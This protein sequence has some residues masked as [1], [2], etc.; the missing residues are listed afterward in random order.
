MAVC[1]Q[2]G[3][4]KTSLILA[5][6]Q[7]M[8]IQEGSITIDGMN[9]QELEPES[10]RTC[11]SI[12][13]QYRFFLPGT[14]RLNIDPHRCASD[15]T[16][17]QAIMLVG[18]WDRISSGGGLETE[19]K[20][21]EWSVGEKQLLALARAMVIR[22]HVLILD[23]ATSRYVK[24]IFETKVYRLIARKVSTWIPRTSCRS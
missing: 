7:M 18:L 20:S 1:G 12:V 24:L 21:S 19:L 22:S 2:S 6:L 10:V 8:E 9:L 5:I 23:E 13:S 4:G 3:S 15:E 17:Q 14:V 11:L 16:I